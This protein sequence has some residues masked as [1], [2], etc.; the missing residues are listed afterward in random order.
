MFAGLA[1]EDDDDASSEEEEPTSKPIPA[2]ARPE[3]SVLPEAD[4]EAACDAPP[5]SQ[6]HPSVEALGG[7]ATLLGGID[8]DDLDITISTLNA[9]AADL[10]LFRSLPFKPLRQALRPLA[11]EL[12]GSGGAK[13]RGRGGRD[14]KKGGTRLDGL[15]PEERL[16]QMDREYA[17]LRLEPQ[18]HPAD[19]STPD[20]S[21]TCARPACSKL[22]AARLTTACCARSGSRASTSSLSRRAPR[23]RRRHHRPLHRRRTLQ[24]WPHL[25]RPPHCRHQKGAPRLL[26]GPSTDVARMGSR[27]G[28]AAS[29]PAAGGGAQLADGPAGVNLG[30]VLPDVAPATL[31]YAQSCYIC[32]ARRAPTPTQTSRPV[33]RRLPTR[34][35]P[36][37]VPSSSAA[38]V[39]GPPPWPPPPRRLLR[40]CH[41]RR[42][43][44]RLRC[45]GALPRA[46]CLL[47]GAPAG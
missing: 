28:T 43:H 20:D 26:G 33:A 27:A 15:S 3:A 1:V 8:P 41:L 40:R 9:V 17:N 10:T 18:G 25:H 19:A 36:S 30:G 35:G 4:D 14:G 42:L 45:P 6:S 47:C 38:N 23:R 12:L 37:L 29:Q 13:Q 7:S 11:E 2:P 21:L 5:L 16:K 31:N 46:A 22:N 44:H 32:K 39:G 34:A 24:P